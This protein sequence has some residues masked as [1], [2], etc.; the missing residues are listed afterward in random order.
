MDLI[1]RLLQQWKGGQQ[2]LTVPGDG[3]G[4]QCYL[5]WQ[6]PVLNGFKKR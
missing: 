6:L 3:A 4:S 5:S 2:T 1:K